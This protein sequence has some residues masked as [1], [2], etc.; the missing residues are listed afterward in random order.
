[1]LHLNSEQTLKM[2]EVKHLFESSS[3]ESKLVFLRDAQSKGLIYDNEEVKVYLKGQ[4]RL[5]HLNDEAERISH[6]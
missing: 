4:L 2:E 6:P 3:Y 1:M 5:M